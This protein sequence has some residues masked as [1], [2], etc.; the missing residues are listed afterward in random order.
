M[1]L[2]FFNLSLAFSY[3]QLM[4]QLTLLP[5]HLIASAMLSL[6]LCLLGLLGACHI[7]FFYSV[8][9][10]QYFCWVN[11]HT[12]LGFLGLFYSFGHPWPI[13][14]LHS[15]GFL[16]NLSGFPGPITIS[17]TFGVYW[18][19]YQ[20]HLFLPLGLFGPFLLAFHFL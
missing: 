5:R 20:L 16:L 3:F 9:V 18:L 15:H 7:L 12:I 11:S 17:F 6:N 4:G 19:L 8:H 2:S 10:A 13:P 1:G 14:I